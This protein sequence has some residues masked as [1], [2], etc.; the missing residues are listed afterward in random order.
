M[1]LTVWLVGR[2]RPLKIPDKVASAMHNSA[3]NDFWD[4]ALSNIN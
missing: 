4:M 2:V 1:A 3:A